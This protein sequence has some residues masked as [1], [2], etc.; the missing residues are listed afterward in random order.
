[1]GVIV[2]DRACYYS[3][4]KASVENAEQDVENAEQDRILGETEYY[5]RPV[6]PAG[7]FL[8]TIVCRCGVFVPLDSPSADVPDSIFRYLI[9]LFAGDA[10]TVTCTFTIPESRKRRKKNKKPAKKNKKQTK[11]NLERLK[12][13][14]RRAENEERKIKNQRRRIKNKRR[15]KRKNELETKRLETLDNKQQLAM[16]AL[17]QAQ[18]RGEVENAADGA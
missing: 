10:V 13:E 6:S 16:E 3:L 2:V 15:I 5:V 14:D 17:W 12:H 4:A 11:N 8:V 18:N 9:P 7:R 1:M